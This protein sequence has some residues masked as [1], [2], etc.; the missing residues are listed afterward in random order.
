M[1]EPRFPIIDLEGPSTLQLTLE[2]RYELVHNVFKHLF[3]G[4]YRHIG[5]TYGWE[6]ANKIAGDVSDESTPILVEL[7]RK[8]FDLD[9]QG[10]ALVS[11][12]IQAEFQGEGSD[13]AV[14]AES[15]DEAELDL[16]CG[17]G[18]AM[19]TPS[20]AI[21]IEHGLCEQGCRVWAQD[22]ARSVDQELRVERLSWMGDGAA[23][24]RYRIW[25]ERAGE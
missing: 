20:L 8:K 24:C 5:E 9:G 3:F 19:R 17:M 10:A 6:A 4:V 23:R 7:F 25:R 16:L 2:Q 1:P 18:A 21:P 12:V 22:L 14:L 15:Q 13:P 11:Q